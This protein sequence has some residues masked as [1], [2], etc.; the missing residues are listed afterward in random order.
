MVTYSM[1]TL[2][3]TSNSASNTKVYS[4]PNQIS[5]TELLAKTFD[6][7]EPENILAKGSM[8]DVWL[9]SEYS[10]VPFISDTKN[11]EVLILSFLTL[12]VFLSWKMIITG[13]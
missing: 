10:T 1:I 13:L 9:D 12:F 8:L 3:K 6:T 7:F 11:W 2:F 4:E 5:K